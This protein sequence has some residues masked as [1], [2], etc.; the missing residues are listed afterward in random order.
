MGTPL[1]PEPLAAG[2]KYLAE[3]GWKAGKHA[4]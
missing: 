2:E 1:E 3:H 4:R